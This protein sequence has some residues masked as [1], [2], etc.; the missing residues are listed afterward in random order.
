MFILSEHRGSHEAL[1]DGMRRYQAYLAEHRA[2]FPAAAYALATAAWYLDPQDPRCPHDAWLEAVTLGE[3]GGGPR[4]AM[5]ATELRVRLLGAY[6]DGHIEL[7]YVA[8]RR[9]EC[10]APDVAAGHGEWLW[11]EFRLGANGDVVHEIEWSGGGRWLVEA[12]DV[13]YCWLPLAA[14]DSPG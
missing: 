12:A 8:V 3:R 7:S 5:R 13:A 11:D 1:A 4:M 10:V 2:A 14:P 9:Y 6:H